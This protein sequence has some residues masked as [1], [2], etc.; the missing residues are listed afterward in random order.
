M[1]PFTFKNDIW[2]HPRLIAELD[3][4]KEWKRKSQLGGLRS[5]EVRRRQT[6]QQ[7]KGGATVVEPTCNSSFVSTSS[8]SKIT[9]TTR[10]SNRQSETDPRVRALQT[11]FFEALKAKFGKAVIFSWAL[12]GMKFKELLKVAGPEDIEKR[13]TR[14]FESQDSHITKRG[15]RI[16]DFHSYFNALASGPINRYTSGSIKPIAGLAASIPGKYQNVEN[17]PSNGNS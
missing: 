14:W 2:T 4:Q 7:V 6:K 3:K 12:S 10:A 16:E 11:I 15:F 9:S 5:G 13:I 8:S 1:A 17:S